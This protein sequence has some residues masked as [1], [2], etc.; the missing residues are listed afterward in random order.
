MNIV[1]AIVFGVAAVG[2]GILYNKLIIKDY[3]EKGRKTAYVLTVVVFVLCAGVFYCAVGV[4]PV[5][6]AAITENIAKME[7]SIKETNASNGFVRNGFDLK[8]IGG[9]TA[10][11][12]R[13]AAEIKSILPTYQQVGL[14]K[15]FYDIVVDNVLKQLVKNMGV[16]DASAKV[17]RSL[18]DENNVV[19]VAS[20]TAS[21]QRSVIT[22]VNI[23]FLIITVIFA[24]ILIVYIIK[25]LL[26]VRK[27][28]KS[29]A[30]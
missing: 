23:I 17:G 28:K 13:A 10:Q 25:S 2:L 9:D 7:Q 30:A 1:L 26:T 8:K 16:L 27:M 18:A 20:I 12:Q 22:V 11:A 24:V 15:S 5:I 29:E 21:I 6:N 4:R 14:P 19:T 3:P